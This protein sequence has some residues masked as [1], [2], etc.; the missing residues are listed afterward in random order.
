MSSTAR[1]AEDLGH[2]PRLPIYRLNVDQYHRLIETGIL[3]EDEPREQK[4]QEPFRMGKGSFYEDTL[5]KSRRTIFFFQGL[6]SAP[7]GR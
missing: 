4:C 5:I 7:R 2:L 3:H 1:P 6:R